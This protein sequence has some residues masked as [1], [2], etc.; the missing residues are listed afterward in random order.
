MATRDTWK[1]RVAQW[2]ASGLSS[3]AFAAGRGFTGSGLRHMAYRLRA[4]PEV[5]L[6]RVEVIAE[7]QTDEVPV[8][9]RVGP[10]V[11]IELT[12]GFSREVL[13]AVLDVVEG[14]RR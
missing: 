8:V 11:R 2:H 4:E 13:V 12:S 6:A 7:R 3:A 1:K 14:R 10:D 5:R 9:V